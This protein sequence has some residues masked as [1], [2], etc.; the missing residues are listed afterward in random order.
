MSLRAFARSVGVASDN[1]V[2]KAIA[3]G[4]LRK[5]VGYNKQ[6]QP[7]IKNPALALREWAANAAKA[8]KGSV[9]L[10]EVQRRVGLE[11]ELKLRFERERDQGLWMKRAE[12]QEGCFTILRVAR[13]TVLNVPSRVSGELAAEQDPAKVFN[14]LDDELRLALS[15]LADQLEALAKKDT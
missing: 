4:R 14:R 7:V 12:V 15:T 10:A 2:R 11:R 13:D 1:A 3:S 8:G 6:G 5:S 9:T